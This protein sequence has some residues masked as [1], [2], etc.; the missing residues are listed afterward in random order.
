[1]KLLFD[2]SVPRPLGTH[3]PLSTPQNNSGS[4][5]RRAYWKIP[6][7]TTDGL[8]LSST[9]RQAEPRLSGNL[10]SHSAD[11]GVDQTDI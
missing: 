11:C 4:L 3:F 10:F 5:S 9:A 6:S 2:E 7:A 8:P 1:M